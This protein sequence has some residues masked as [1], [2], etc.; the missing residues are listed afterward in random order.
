MYL[1]LHLP[2]I[3]NT[4]IVLRDLSR[5]QMLWQISSR[6]PYTYMTEVGTNMQQ[7][8][9]RLSWSLQ[10]VYW[11]NL[12]STL[13]NHWRI[14]IARKDYNHKDVA[15]KKKLDVGSERLLVKEWTEFEE[16]WG[17]TYASLEYYN[18]ISWKNSS[19]HGRM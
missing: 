7:I 4:A 6:Q 9:I 11:L 2:W 15:K 3:D 10:N 16:A 17:K 13:W 12:V 19:H 5:R 8:F 1:E 18:L 14:N